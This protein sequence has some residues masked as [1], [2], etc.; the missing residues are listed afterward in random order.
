M[1]DAKKILP[2]PVGDFPALVRGEDGNLHIR[3]F[4]T[5]ADAAAASS[6]RELPPPDQVQIV[7]GVRRGWIQSTK[8]A[9][10]HGLH[11]RRIRRAYQ[12][13]ELPGCIE[14]GAHTLMVPSH[15]DR[16]I[17]AYGL[18]G[19]GQMAKAGLI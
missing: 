9:K 12:N 2:P 1:S 5:S 18:R 14:H 17:S 10:K 15:L 16:L 19:V 7:C 4:P 8:L 3:K 13:G 11:P 6:D